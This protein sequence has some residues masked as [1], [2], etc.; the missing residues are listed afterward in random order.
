MNNENDQLRAQTV[1]QYVGVPLSQVPSADDLLGTWEVRFTGPTGSDE[2][3][4]TYG[5][6]PDGTV[7][8]ADETWTWKLN[9]DGTLIFLITTPPDPT[10]PGLEDGEVTE[11][12]YFPFKAN[13]GRLVLA[14]DDTSVVELL[15]PI[16]R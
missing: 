7:K 13:D 2:V 11:E 14:N 10:I 15:S 9:D 4:W 12:L 16:R 5:F 6:S 8:V 1:E 3:Q